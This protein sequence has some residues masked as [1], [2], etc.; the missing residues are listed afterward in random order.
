MKNVNFSPIARGG[1]GEKR[2]IGFLIIV[3]ALLC[4]FTFYL[5]KDDLANKFLES[6]PEF[7]NIHLEMN[8]R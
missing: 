1:K 6:D 8:R 3:L 4:I 7:G 5:K 2:G